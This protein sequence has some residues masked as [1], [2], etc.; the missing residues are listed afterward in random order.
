[1]PFAIN[2]FTASLGDSARNLIVDTGKQVVVLI[3]EYDAPMHDSINNKDLQKTI[4]NVMR[5][6]FKSMSESMP[7]RFT[8]LIECASYISIPPK[9]PY[10]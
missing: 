1:M 10:C 9:S 8:F 5:D 6:L 4:R 7:S 3:D 2:D